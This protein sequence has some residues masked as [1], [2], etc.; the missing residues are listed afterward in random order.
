MNGCPKAMTFGPCGGVRADE[1]CEVDGRRCPFCDLPALPMWSPTADTPRDRPADAARL[2]ARV[3]VDFRPD[4]TLDWEI[5]EATR[6]LAAAG[7]GLLIGEH[8]DDLTPHGPATVAGA[9]TAHGLPVI[10]TVTCRDRTRDELSAEIEALRD[11]RVAAV[12]CVTGDH[13]AARLGLDVNPDYR[14]DGTALAALAAGSGRV[15]VAESPASPPTDWRAR[16]VLSKQRAGASVAILNHAGGPRRLADFAH[17]CRVAGVDLDLIAPVPVITDH[18][19]AD[20]LD[21]FPGLE[22][23]TG[24]V[25][26]ILESE[27][28]HRTGIDAAIALGAELLE[29]GDFAAVNLSGSAGDGGLVERAEIM[30][31]VARGLR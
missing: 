6:P 5:A 12:H 10:A 30:A 26:S 17:E 24:L 18:R 7:A 31:T 14:L 19:S 20:A 13:P 25:R 29:S 28:P 16:R 2:A 11:A 4:P 27:D 9:V 3:W 1:T 8:V 15:S 23:P 21:R 22:L